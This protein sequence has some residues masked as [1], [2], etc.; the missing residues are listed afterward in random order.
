MDH[1]LVSVISLVYNTKK[2][3][4]DKCI[5]SILNQTYQN[6][7]IIILDDC[8]SKCTYDYLKKLSPKI[9]LIRNEKN[10]GFNRNTQKG[11][12][13][14]TGKYIVKVDS[15][16]YIDPT[17]LEREVKLLENNPQTGA[18]ACELQRFGK[19]H[20]CIR[21][22]IKW[23]LQEAL[24]KNMNQYGYEGGL[25]FRAELLKEISID[26]NFRVCTDFDFN[27]QILERMEIKSIHAPL[28]YYR[29]HDENIMISAQGGERVD[30]VNAIIQ[31]HCNL[32]YA[33]YGKNPAL[34]PI[35]LK[36]KHRY[37]NYKPQKPSVIVRATDQRIKPKNK[38]F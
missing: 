13:L 25:M 28:Y 6:F 30:I 11:F 23:D 1:P 33:K 32:Y 35:V 22:P 5:D 4:V 21:R 15:D 31:K 12:D 36:L 34:K 7:E 19:K 2:E 10:L 3:Y 8:S 37:T 17:L 27:L 16:D 29:S 26:P 18:V 9:K 24:F 14:A 20:T 38:Y